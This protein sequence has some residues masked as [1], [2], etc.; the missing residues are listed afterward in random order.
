[1]A[2]MSPTPHKDSYKNTDRFV[3][4][5]HDIVHEIIE[6]EVVIVN[7]KNG[8]YYS[9]ENT[10]SAIWARLTGGRSYGEILGFLAGRYPGQEE[11]IVAATAGFIDELLAEHLIEVSADEAG[12]TEADETADRLSPD[13]QAPVLHRHQDMQDLLLVDPI[14]EVEDSGWPNR[15]QGA[16]VES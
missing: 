15:K 8:Y 12:A 7:L 6:G 1:M 13:F 11:A 9:S 16:D 2:A 4:A 3:P 14:H 10:G 5:G